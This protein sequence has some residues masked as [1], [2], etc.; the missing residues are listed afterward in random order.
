MKRILL[1]ATLALAA[2]TPCALPGADIF[3]NPNRFSLGPRF[4]LNYKADFQ[5][6]A[7]F[8]STVNPG[9]AAGGVNH[10]YNDGY[11]L[12]DASGNLGGLT[13]FW[14]Y[15]NPSQVVG[16]SIEFHAV[17]TSA[18][19]STTDDPQ[20][21]LEFLYQRVLGELPLFSSGL[22][23]LEAG[24]GYTD[25]DLNSRGR[26][27]APVLTDTF[28]IGVLPPLAGYNGTFTGPGAL[29]GDTPVR[30][31]GSASVTGNQRLSGRLFSI[32]LGPFVEWQLA[33][34][35]SLAA[36]AGMTLAPTSLDYE[37]WETYTLA[38]GVSFTES[39]QTSRT[40]LLIGPYVGTT[41]RYD[42]SDNWG[43]YLGAQF[44]RLTDMGL[45][46]G[47]RTARFNPGATFNLSTGV[48]WRF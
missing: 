25:L 14:G 17:Q 42:F 20:Y 30:T 39:G 12:V 35:L 6:N 9:L 44:Q 11:V 28:P 45:S 41:L 26:G 36:S 13:T 5:N 18:A 23:G 37:Y 47:S 29:L 33:P 2:A 7:S 21:G 48:T 38:S 27:S 31:F 24:F 19:S 46:T 34:R 32:R 4:G 16:P 15:Q 8:F 1:S 22:W 10:T 40:R 3:D 43:V